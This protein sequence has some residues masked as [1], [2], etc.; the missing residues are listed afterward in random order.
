MSADIIQARYDQL[1]RVAGRFAKASEANAELHARVMR[2]VEVL[3]RGGWQGRGADAFF[4]E[5]HS[6]LYPA[7][8]RL[9]KA[10]AE[11]RAVTLQAKDI[12][13]AAEEE[14][15]RLFQGNGASVDPDSSANAN[16]TSATQATYSQEARNNPELGKAPASMTDIVQLLYKQQTPITIIETGPMQYLVLLKGTDFGNWTL[17]NNGV[18]AF[19]GAFALPGRYERQVRELIQQNVK[20]GASINFVG[21]SLGGIVANNLT[22]NQDFN[23]RYHIQSVTTIGSPQTSQ[24]RSDVEYHRYRNANDPVPFLDGGL[25]APSVVDMNKQGAE[26]NSQ[27]LVHSGHVFTAH[28]MEHYAQAPELAVLPPPQRLD[29]S[30]WSGAEIVVSATTEINR[31]A[32]AQNPFF[33]IAD[34]SFEAVGSGVLAIG[35]RA[36]E[37]GSSHLSPDLRDRVDRYTDR[38]KYLLMENTPTPSEAISNVIDIYK[39]G[40]QNARRFFSPSSGW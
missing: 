28:N 22:D 29:L 34:R 10:L 6:T 33:T 37:V 12:L 16:S 9:S 15:A 32:F 40:E 3:E 8:Q 25:I 17:T 35:N 26:L 27:Q 14:A 13:R 1:D 7:M 2:C 11:G 18:S 31:P 5:M 30:H 39:Q 36:V 38:A 23:E 19:Q 20:P 24:I 4:A 21:H